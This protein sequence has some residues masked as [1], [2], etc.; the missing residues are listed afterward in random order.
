MS[1]TNLIHRRLDFADLHRWLRCILR[2]NLAIQ[3]IPPTPGQL[4]F[5]M[6]EQRLLQGEKT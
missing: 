6:L 4:S 5:R 2:D 1:A 3:C